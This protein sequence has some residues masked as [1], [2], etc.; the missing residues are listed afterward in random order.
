MFCATAVGS[1]ISEPNFLSSCCWK[2]GCFGDSLCHGAPSRRQGCR[3]YIYISSS[4]HWNKNWKLYNTIP[5][6]TPLV[7]I[8][9]FP[10]VIVFL[11][12]GIV[13]YTQGLFCRCF[14]MRVSTWGLLVMWSISC[15]AL[16]HPLKS[17]L[18]CLLNFTGILKNFTTT[19]YNGENDGVSA[20]PI[21]ITLSRR[22]QT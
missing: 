2:S 16:A 6:S 14:V 22:N 8:F 9:F 5:M 13:L 15:V 1:R 20:R 7:C 17:A 4:T 19:I 12:A 11:C 18:N 21:V 10:I 3:V